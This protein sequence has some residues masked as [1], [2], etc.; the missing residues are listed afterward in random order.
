RKWGRVVPLGRAAK[1]EEMVGAAVFLA[2][3]MASYVTGQVFYV[4]GGWTTRGA[5]PDLDFVQEKYAGGGSAAAGA[6][7]G[8]SGSR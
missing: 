5:T 7:A 8:D 3:D 1:A 6:S 2:S 4:D